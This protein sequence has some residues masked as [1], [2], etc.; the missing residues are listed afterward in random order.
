LASVGSE[1]ALREALWRFAEEPELRREIGPRLRACRRDHPEALEG[2]R[3]GHDEHVRRGL[4]EFLAWDV[5]DALSGGDPLAP[6]D[7]RARKVAVLLIKEKSTGEYETDFRAFVPVEDANLPEDYEIRLF[8]GYVGTNLL[9]I[10]LFVKGRR[11]FGEMITKQGVSR[12]EV[13]FDEVDAF[14]RRAFYL[15]RAQEVQIVDWIGRHRSWISHA[16]YLSFQLSRRGAA[17]HPLLATGPAKAL[18]GRIHSDFCGGLRP[19]AHSWACNNLRHL[20]REHL[21]PA[22]VTG[23][24][25]RTILERLSAFEPETPPLDDYRR[26]DRA[27]IEAQLYARL[28]L[29]WNVAGALPVLE[30]LGLDEHADRLRIRQADDPGPLLKAALAGNDWGLTTWALGCMDGMPDVEAAREVLLHGLRAS[31]SK[32]LP[33]R[34]LQR[35]ALLPRDAATTEAIEA[36]FEKAPPHSVTRVAAARALLFLTDREKHFE[37]LRTEAL[38][39]A[40]DL[41]DLPKPQREALKAITA[42][43]AGTGQS[44]PGFGAARPRAGRWCDRAAETVITV[45]DRIPADAH[46]TFSGMDMLVGLLGDLGRPEDADVVGRYAR[47]D[48]DYMAQRA[49]FAM[50]T[51]DRHRAVEEARRRVRLFVQSRGGK[52]SYSWNARGYWWLFCAL[53]AR[54]AVPEAEQVLALLKRGPPPQRTPEKDAPVASDHLSWKHFRCGWTGHREAP[55]IEALLGLLRAATPAERAGYAVEFVR[56]YRPYYD[57]RL[58]GVLRDRLIRDGVGR[59]TVPEL[60]AEPGKKKRGAPGR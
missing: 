6:R 25:R 52:H 29:E 60:F 15:L 34:L 55:R 22:E 17:R 51:L 31:R 11:V 21:R 56:L 4:A 40:P 41:N 12:G 36:A 3:E 8:G 9:S 37:F 28:L 43:A 32:Y 48:S 44:R 38:A 24:L 18:V 5:E 10:R 20:A 46:T 35:L 13:P 27:A 19:F 2:I 26:K 58:L 45:L 49:V 7:S 33:E 30:R 14:A 54:E 42:Y 50:A 57:Q 39:S 47:H 23:D 16:P 53:E 1:H 59:D